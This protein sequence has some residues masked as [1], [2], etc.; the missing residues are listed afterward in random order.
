LAGFGDASFSGDH[1]E[2]SKVVVVEPFHGVR[3][4]PKFRGEDTHIF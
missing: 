3:I 1:P 4:H 2:V